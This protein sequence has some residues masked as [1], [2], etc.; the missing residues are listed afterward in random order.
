MT[1]GRQHSLPVD[2]QDDQYRR[3]PNGCDIPT[4]PR[5]SNL[6][7]LAKE[8]LVIRTH[9]ANIV[10]SVPIYPNAMKCKPVI[11]L[12]PRIAPAQCPT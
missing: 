6:Y 2:I 7:G 3:L 10:L 12:S 11:T 1:K 8:S 5:S 9:M 4:V